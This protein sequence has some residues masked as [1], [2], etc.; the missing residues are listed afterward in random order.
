MLQITQRAIDHLE[1]LRSEKGLDGR[2]G[3][4]FVRNGVR[5]GL[6]FTV[7]PEAGD[8]L[9]PRPG[10]AIYLAPAVAEAFD[11]SIIDAKA[12]EDRVRLVLTPQHPV[13][14]GLPH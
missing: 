5:L 6:T 1:H 7:A 13:F 12:G 10:I 14:D 2:A 4:R 8:R 11:R 9:V 3:V